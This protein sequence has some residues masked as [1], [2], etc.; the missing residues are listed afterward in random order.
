MNKLAILFISLMLVGCGDY[1]YPPEPCKEVILNY[2]LYVNSPG[3]LDWS[4][5]LVSRV[6]VVKK[7]PTETIMKTS[8]RA[9]PLED[10]HD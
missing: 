10:D 1:E 9:L 6:C 5:P 7:T 3:I 2:Y 8:I 4:G